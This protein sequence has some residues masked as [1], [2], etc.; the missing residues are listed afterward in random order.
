MLCRFLWCIIFYKLI[1]LK[2]RFNNKK[3]HETPSY[4]INEKLH[5]W[6][7]FDFGNLWYCIISITSLLLLYLMLRESFEDRLFGKSK[8]KMVFEVA[9]SFVCA[10]PRRVEF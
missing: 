10:A 7:F 6:I 5:F 9:F 8:A 4:D 2:S 1:L 3:K